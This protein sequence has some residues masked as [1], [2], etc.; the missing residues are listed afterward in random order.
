MRK[1]LQNRRK[2][3]ELWK[4]LEEQAK[5][6]QTSFEANAALA[7]ILIF[8]I[9]YVFEI[10]YL[11]ILW[12]IVAISAAMQKWRNIWKWEWYEQGFVEWFDKWCE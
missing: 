5:Q 6:P 4:A 7:A 11:E 10:Q 3:I 1:L 12:V 9:T 2:N 8:T